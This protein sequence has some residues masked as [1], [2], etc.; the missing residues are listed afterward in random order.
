MGG[1]CLYNSPRPRARGARTPAAHNSATI[2]RR[3]GRSPALLTV[4][5]PGGW[6]VG[7]ATLSSAAAA[8]AIVRAA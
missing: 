2:P 1:G 5:R 7:V 8:V 6:R 4:C 3:D